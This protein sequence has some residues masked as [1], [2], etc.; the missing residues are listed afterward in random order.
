MFQRAECAFREK[1]DLCGG[2]TF[3]N[4]SSLV[5]IGCALQMNFFTWESPLISPLVLPSPER[6]LKIGLQI[7]PGSDALTRTR[8]FPWWGHH[9]PRTQTSSSRGKASEQDSSQIDTSCLL[10]S[11]FLGLSDWVFFLHRINFYWLLRSD[12]DYIQS[13]SIAVNG[14]ES[15]MLVLLIINLHSWW[16]SFLTFLTTSSLMMPDCRHRITQRS[17]TK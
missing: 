4:S 9:R 7:F 6:K 14:H 15:A 8:R 10:L 16:F 12:E 5:N 3:A 13:S 17:N 11:V 2:L 1:E